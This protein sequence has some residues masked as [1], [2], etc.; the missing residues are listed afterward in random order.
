M[1]IAPC[2]VS[3]SQSRFKTVDFTI[4]W[5]IDPLRLVVPWPKEEHQQLIAVTR[6][7]QM[8]VSFF[9]NLTNVTYLFMK[10]YGII[11]FIILNCM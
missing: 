1:D 7:F 2:G 10:A 5:L 6:P 8:A 11:Y 9:S 4:P 3:M